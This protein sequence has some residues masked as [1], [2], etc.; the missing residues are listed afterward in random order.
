MDL[1]VHHWDAD[2]ICSAALIARHLV[3]GDFLNTSPKIGEYRFDERIHRLIDGADSIFVADLNAPEEVEKIEKPT[4]YFDHHIQPRIDSRTVRQINPA[5]RGDKPASCAAVISRHLGK[6]SAETVIGTVGDVD[7]LAFMIPEIRRT[8]EKLEMSERQAVRLAELIDSNH[9]SG[10]RDAVEQAVKVVLE[11]EWRDL[12][13]HEPWIRQTQEIE[14]EIERALSGV[15]SR[16]EHAFLEFKSSFN[17]I[18]RVARA[19]VWEMGFYEAL[20]INRD[21]N[22]KVQIYYRVSK[23][24][25]PERDISGI[26]SG[27]KRAGISAGGKDEV[28]GCVFEPEKFD[29]VMEILRSHVRWLD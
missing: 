16:N 8:M 28:V 3:E 18:S 9:I 12:L 2:G 22:G 11:N 1:I 15:D 4:L 25:A 7:K 13:E 23:E 29:R 20:V 5:I 27:L 19:L 14:K 17:I 26:I 24:I 21:F 10:S 6:W